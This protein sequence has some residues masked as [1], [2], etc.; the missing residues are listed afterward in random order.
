MRFSSKTNIDFISK[1]RLTGLLSIVLI[2]AGIASLIMK[3]GP[4]LSID[5]TGGPVAQVKFETYGLAL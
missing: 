2:I 5:F 1:Q 4:T 3:G